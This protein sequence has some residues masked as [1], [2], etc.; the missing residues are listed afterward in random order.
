MDEI[1]AQNTEIA[2]LQIVDVVIYVEAIE[3]PELRYR[4]DVVIKIDATESNFTLVY[5]G[6]K[7]AI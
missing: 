7:E 6:D 1:T 3:Y 4:E 2:L 5:K